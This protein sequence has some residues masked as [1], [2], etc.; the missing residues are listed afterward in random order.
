LV[1]KAKASDKGDLV[2]QNL[3]SKFIWTDVR[4]ADLPNYRKKKKDSKRAAAHKT[5]AENK[6]K[7]IGNI[8]N[9]ESE[10]KKPKPADKQPSL[11]S[12]FPSTPTPDDSGTGTEGGQ[13]DE[14][15]D[16]SSLITPSLTIDPLINCSKSQ[17]YFPDTPKHLHVLRL[18]H[19]WKGDED[20]F[21]LIRKLAQELLASKGG[22][23]KP[24]MAG[25]MKNVNMDMCALIFR[26]QVAVAK[27]QGLNDPGFTPVTLIKLLLDQV[28]FHS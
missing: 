25:H 18:K 13:G 26:V 24:I 9:D 27:L 14:H 23:W 7:R 17:E 12:S 4:F 28:C 20:S 5:A 10:R 19:I 11:A 2:T 8:E 3:L 22:T 21:N 16:P 1:K 6:R 15:P